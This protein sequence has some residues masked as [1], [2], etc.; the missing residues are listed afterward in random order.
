MTPRMS[1]AILQL[2]PDLKVRRSGCPYKKR[3]LANARLVLRTFLKHSR[4]LRAGTER[5]RG[6]RPKP[7]VRK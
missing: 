1:I 3:P 4:V 6:E 2:V 7:L 5:R